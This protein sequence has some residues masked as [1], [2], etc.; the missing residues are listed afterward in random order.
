MLSILQNERLEC[1]FFVTGD[2]LSSMP[3]ML[4]YE[5]LYLM[6]SDSQ[7][8]ELQFCI[9]SVPLKF[10]LASVEQKRLAWWV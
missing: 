10:S 6:I 9:E 3:R 7:I 4:W 1:L 8:R 2:F 5:E